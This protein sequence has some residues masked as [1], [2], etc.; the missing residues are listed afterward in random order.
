[1]SQNNQN[2]PPHLVAQ[3]KYPVAPPPPYTEFAAG[4]SSSPSPGVFSP[5][6]SPLNA[7][8]THPARMPPQMPVG[9]PPMPHAAPHPGYGPTPLATN[10][11]LLPYAYYAPRGSADSRAR[12]RFSWAMLWAVSLWM[13]FG[14]MIG[15]EVW[16]DEGWDLKGWAVRFGLDG[17]VR[18]WLRFKVTGGAVRF[19]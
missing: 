8:Y 12:W 2:V 14:F 10:Q 13:I 3:N 17:A 16:G 4:S 18:A 15:V 19:E 1:M 11:P 9:V 6:Q 5:A 7:Q